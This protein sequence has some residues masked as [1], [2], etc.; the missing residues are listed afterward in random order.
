MPAS[1]GTASLLKNEIVLT[2]LNID[3]LYHFDIQL[4]SYRKV[5]NLQAN[6]YKYVMKNWILSNEGKFYE[7]SGKSL[8]DFKS[9]NIIFKL[10][11][12]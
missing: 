11:P 1:Y 2:G 5:L 4:N 7:N 6:Y 10:K 9:Y 8:T 3:G 12:H